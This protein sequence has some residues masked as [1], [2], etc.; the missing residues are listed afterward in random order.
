MTI[1]ILESAVCLSALYGFYYLVLRRETFF[2]WN[3]IFLLFSPLVALLLPA[4]NIPL[5]YH[6]EA[7]NSD[8]SPVASSTEIY[9]PGL[10]EQAQSVP[11]QVAYNLNLPA[12]GGWEISL[13]EVIWYLYLFGAALLLIRLMVRIWALY[14]LVKRCKTAYQVG[15]HTVL[16]GE[17]APTASFFGYIFWN[18]TDHHDEEEKLLLAHELVHVKQWHSVDVVMMELMVLVQWFNPLMHAF[19]SSLCAMHE[20]IADEYVVH[21]T[22]ERHA[23]ATLLVQHQIAEP[24]A[25]P[26]LVN[27]FHS[28]IKHRLIMLAK[29]PSHPLRRVKYLLALPIFTALLLLFSFRLIEHLPGTA[30]LHQAVQQVAQYSETLSEITILSEK[31]TTIEPTPYRFYWGSLQCLIERDAVSGTY[32]GRI[33]TSP[34]ELLVSLMNREPRMFNGHGLE[35]VIDFKIQHLNLKSN[36]SDE[37]IFS[38]YRA[39]AE[40]LFLNFTSAD[41]FEITDL[42]LPNGAKATITFT[43]DQ[44]P[45]NWLPKKSAG[46]INWQQNP[47]LSDPS[48]QMPSIE[49]GEYDPNRQFYLVDEFW[50]ILNSDLKITMPDGGYL[51][52][53]PKTNNITAKL[54]DY[55]LTFDIS[56]ISFDQ[57]KSPS[58]FIF[59]MGKSFSLPELRVFLE[60]KRDEIKPEQWI[61]LYWRVISKQ[62]E[63]EAIPSTFTQVSEPEM[64][65]FTL[66][67]PGDPRLRLRRSAVSDYSFQWGQISTRFLK[68]YGVVFQGKHLNITPD[69][70]MVTVINTLRVKDIVETLKLSPR[71]YK[72]KN[73]N[74]QSLLEGLTFKMT[75]KTTVTTISNGVVP[76]GIIQIIRDQMKPDETIYLSDFRTADGTQLPNASITISARTDNNKPALSDKYLFQWETFEMGMKRKSLELEGDTIFMSPSK[77]QSLINMMMAKPRLVFE[78]RLVSKISFRIKYGDQVIKVNEDG[79]ASKQV[80]KLTEALQNGT[81]FWLYDFKADGVPLHHTTFVFSAADPKVT[82]RNHAQSSS[83]TTL[84]SLRVE[85]N[86]VTDKAQFMFNIPNKSKVYFIISDPSGKV[87]HSQTSVFEA[88]NNSI[89]LPTQEIKAKG[90]LFAVLETADGKVTT[91]FVVEY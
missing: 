54:K 63:P 28:L 40:A 74:D 84:L 83:A 49:W 14:K 87:V 52:I 31:T 21:Q 88:G 43:L 18:K 24:R 85:P 8:T 3:R 58:P 79:L 66:V 36:Y 72:I 82:N 73:P 51:E 19:R 71:L 7:T 1:Y 81:D 61:G 44:N 45:P 26:A 69:R 30:P 80:K 76:E 34:E 89:V 6:Q 42:T 91:K 37:A 20:Y 10:V 48:S 32:M 11:Q 22:Q 29:H 75:Y 90:I 67:S 60:S 25:R 47:D 13:G 56:G 77:I 65:S 62:I 70:K 64:A 16:A 33:E 4:L 41:Q 46:E 17:N 2:Q 55:D 23:Y 57:E 39:E 50:N 9:L 12:Y 53:D 59:P 86:P 15:S 35:Q 5:R 68:Q 78:G 27:T 38:A